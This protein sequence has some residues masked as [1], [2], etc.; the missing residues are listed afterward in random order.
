MNVRHICEESL[1]LLSNTTFLKDVLLDQKYF[2]LC[3]IKK[4]FLLNK[5]LVIY[6][7]KINEVNPYL[8]L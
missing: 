4:I 3:C 7:L 8:E 5:S 2:I 1:Y 6:I